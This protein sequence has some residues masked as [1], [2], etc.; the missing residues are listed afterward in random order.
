M[1]KMYFLNILY[2]ND[3]DRIFLYRIILY[4]IINEQAFTCY[5]KKLLGCKYI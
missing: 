4:V 2:I 5:I 3:L 1:N